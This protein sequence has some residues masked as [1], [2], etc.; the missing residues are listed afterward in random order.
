M[1]F[2]FEKYNLEVFK[3]GVRLPEI[4]ISEKQKEDIGLSCGSSNIQYLKKLCWTKCLE[5]IKSGQIKQSKSECIDRL[6][7]EFSV[8]EKTNT[9]D[10]ILLLMDI[11]LWCD[12]NDI[13]RGPARGSAAASFT[14]FCLDLTRQVNPLDYNLNFT[15]FLSEAR[16]KVTIRDGIAYVDGKSM[17]DFDGDIEY[18]GREKCLQRINKDYHG[19]SCKILTLQ[20]LTSKTSLKETVKSL[21]EYSED[22]ALE[23]GSEIESVFGKVDSLEKAL[24]KSAKLQ[25]WAQTEDG[26]EAI[27]VAK[28][29][30]GLYRASGVHASGIILSYY[31]IEEIFP[32]ELCSTG[33]EVSGYDMSEC[34]QVAVKADILGLRTLTQLTIME[35]LTGIKCSSINVN[36]LSIYRYFLDERKCFNGLFQIEEGITK[37]AALKIK[38]KNI[39]EL[40]IVV[41]ISRPGG[42]KHID[43]MAKFTNFG[44]YKSF[45]PQI[46][47]I[48][49]KT[50][51]IIL[52]QEQINDICQK[53]YGMSPTDADEVRRAIGKK[54]KSDMEKW[55]PVIKQNGLNRRIPE[56]VTQKFWD[57]CIESSDYLFNAAHA[58]SYSYITAYTLYFKANFPLEFFLSCLRTSGLEAD[59]TLYISNFNNELKHFNIKLLPPDILH[60]KEDFAIEGPNI[61]MGLSAIKGLSESSLQ[62]MRS[63]KAVVT[64]RFDLYASLNDANIPVN[65]VSALV[66]SGCF[67][68][69]RGDLSRNKFLFEFE[70]W[71]LLTEKELIF[72]KSLGAQYNYNLFDIIV[73]LKEKIQN[74]KGKFIIK[75]SRFE[76]IRKNAAPFKEK[77]LKNSK[78]E[79]LSSWMF[80]Q[81]YIGFSY[82]NKLI[83]I[84][85]N[86]INDLI[87]IFDIKNLEDKTKVRFVGIV[88]SVEK[89]I[90]REKKNPYLKV[91]IKDDS[92][93]IMGMLFGDN[94]IEAT[95]SFNGKEIEEGDIVVVNGQKSN[96]LVFIDTLAIQD[97][98]IIMS[99]RQLK[100]LDKNKV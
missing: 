54:N 35:E 5:K 82:S 8:F 73:A 40:A 61:R 3:H 11:Y 46:D 81:R 2:T 68:S 6:K 86:N 1:S 48:L 16:A 94:R 57:T 56:E 74:E 99:K 13:M 41:A 88:E 37:E 93:L 17:C 25:K 83:N 72:V 91:M 23:L 65:V 69:L 31:P 76:T 84:Y 21:L 33:E 42:M 97:N 87:P 63:F 95:N 43:E 89:R 44:E 28:A 10:Y 9:I 38:P 55:E 53:V 59:P 22:Q 67:D 80:E 51:C 58:I 47:S 79:L 39:E 20:Y 49:K 34:L 29:L 26:K 71:N 92:S 98:P 15:R 70:I 19:K 90:S 75:E 24:E 52:Y 50:G 30:E 78:Y 4:N 100:D 85:K 18:Y 64:N 12:K 14:L 62:K 36:D 96:E 7:M 27:K 32:R 66:L 77:Y 60:S 45:Y